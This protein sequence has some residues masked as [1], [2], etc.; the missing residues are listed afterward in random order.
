MLPS[1]CRIG[2]FAA[3]ELVAKVNFIFFGGSDFLWS[4]MTKIIDDSVSLKN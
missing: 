3:G 4:I 2:S 1:Y